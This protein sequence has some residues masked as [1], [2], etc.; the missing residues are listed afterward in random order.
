MGKLHQV[1]FFALSGLPVSTMAQVPYKRIEHER[2][3]DRS[4]WPRGKQTVRRHRRGRWRGCHFGA[5][6]TQTSPVGSS[7]V[8][9]DLQTAVTH[10]Q[11]VM[12]VR[13]PR[14]DA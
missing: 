13:G 6:Q 11:R 9:A 3:A 4:R 7:L 14:A 12:R 5:A 2:P 1:I 8:A 10:K